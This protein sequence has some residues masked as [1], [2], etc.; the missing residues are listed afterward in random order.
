MKVRLFRNNGVTYFIICILIFTMTIQGPDNQL[1]DIPHIVLNGVTPTTIVFFLGIALILLHIA[2]QDSSVDII[3]LLLVARVVIAI[4]PTFY[5]VKMPDFYGHLET[6]M[7]CAI[8]YFIGK[9]YVDDT[10]KI[11][12]A[13]FLMFVILSLQAILEAYLGPVSYFADTYYFKNNLIIPIGGS[14][15]IASRLV[16]CFAY[17]FCV[18]E[19]RYKKGMLTVILFILL[20]VTKS[21]SGIIAGALMLAIVCIWK[22]HLSV[23]QIIKIV[24][25]LIV[26]VGVFYIFLNQTVVGRYAFYDN[27]STILNR[28]SRW[29]ISMDLFWKY[30]LFGTSYLT[31]EADYN[32][33][34]WII[35]IMARGGIVGI[36]IAVLII[37]LF[38]IEFKG[39][40]GNDIV[41]GATC[42]A[43]SMLIQGLA[44][45]T[46][47]TSGHDLFF[48]FILGVAM[49]EVNSMVDMKELEYEQEYIRE[50]RC[51]KRN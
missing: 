50:E 12:T 8:V 9:N 29:K 2:I 19:E 5:I 44:E 38:L 45:I 6:T 34:N 3:T 22:G 10:Y 7:L 27:V 17:L 41:R 11:K 14:N 42:F 51:L 32:P 26:I 49:K 30:P 13:I 21:R 35:S 28:F 46:L 48:W 39:N 31:Q 23:K 33:H 37:A 47:F 15:A 36:I 20:V 18:T 1:I 25:F 40:Y 43:L 4:I 16:P 24:T